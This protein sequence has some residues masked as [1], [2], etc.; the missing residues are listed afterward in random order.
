M[1]TSILLVDHHS[2]LRQ[3]LR[4]LLATTH[5]EFDV[6]GEA[7]DG[8]EAVLRAV[9]FTP[10]L[11]LIDSRLPGLSGSETMAQIKRRLPGVRIVVFS[12]AL[13]DDCVR[14]SLSAGVDGFVLKGSTFDELLTALRSVASGKKY[15]SPE[16]SAL[17]VDAYLNPTAA[18]DAEPI[19]KLT[20]RERSILQL[21]AEGRTNRATAAYLSVS[22]KTVEKHRS[23]LMR[24]L[25]LHS[26]M[27]LM[28]A[29]LDMGLAQRPAP[30]LRHPDAPSFEAQST[31]L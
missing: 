11:M 4:A 30:G 16:V 27:E 31:A 19:S 6:V 23:N 15:L 10:D 3:G 17:L 2:M 22:Q 26:A 28:L 25:G 5:G 21:I 1:T 9:Q 8:R 13:T 18:R 29:A 7:R 24:K 12:D 20:A 14:E